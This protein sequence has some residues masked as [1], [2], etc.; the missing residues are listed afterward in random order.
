MLDTIGYLTRGSGSWNGV[1][2]IPGLTTTEV[3]GGPAMIQTNPKNAYNLQATIRG[4]P[5]LT[6]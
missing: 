1:G 3:G 6:A 4:R 5:K 2:A